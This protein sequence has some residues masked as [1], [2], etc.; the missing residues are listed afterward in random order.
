MK[1]SF[2]NLF[3]RIKECEESREKVPFV[4]IIDDI[5]AKLSLLSSNLLAKIMTDY[6]MVLNK[7]QEIEAGFEARI[8]G[9]G[10][11]ASSNP[12]EGL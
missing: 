12:L 1:P 4:A 7:L 11:S 9:A 3:F 8:G 5:L 10:G 6:Q 2:Y